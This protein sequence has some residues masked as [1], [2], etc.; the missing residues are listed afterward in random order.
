[1]PTRSCR[2]QPSAESTS[3]SRLCRCRRAWRHF[4]N[5]G[6]TSVLTYV[7]C[8]RWFYPVTLIDGMA[9]VMRERPDVGLVLCGGLG[10]A[11]PG[12]WPAVQ[13]AFNAIRCR[14][15]SVSWMTSITTR[16]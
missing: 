16:F 8:D 3:S 7:E 11:D 1:M 4:C 14:I 13:S 5:A 12:V 2:S 15:G 9:K 10:H 6:E